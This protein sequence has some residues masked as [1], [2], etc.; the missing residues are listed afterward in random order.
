MAA[1]S[2]FLPGSTE[3]PSECIYR[4]RPGIKA[5]YLHL[6]GVHVEDNGLLPLRY[7]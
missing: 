2:G 4:S 1:C 3:K 7:V 5:L 6:P